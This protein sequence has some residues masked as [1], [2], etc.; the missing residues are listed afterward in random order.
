MHDRAKDIVLFV[1]FHLSLSL[2][3]SL[4]SLSL[5]TGGVFLVALFLPFA[6]LR[7]L[8][9]FLSLSLSRLALV[10][11]RERWGERERER[12][13]ERERGDLLL[14]EIGVIEREKRGKERLE[15][16]RMNNLS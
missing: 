5:S 3:P 12:R 7:Y 9:L 16:E 4:L 1:R 14:D 11:L 2:R 6:P 8:S 10:R 15:N 13:R